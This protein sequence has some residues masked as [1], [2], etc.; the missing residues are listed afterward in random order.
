[1]IFRDIQKNH[2]VY[3]LDKSKVELSQ[4][5]V[6]E[7]APHISAPSVNT[8]ASGTQPMRDVTIEVGGK[9]TA[10]TIPEHLSVTYAG[11]LVLATERSGLIAEVEKMKNEAESVLESVERMKQVREKSDLLLASLNP[12]VREKQ[13]TERRFKSIEGDISGIKGMMQKLLDKLS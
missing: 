2:P 7:A 11:E 12:A 4:G 1:M 6:V 3:I 8:I 9:M 13:E 10:Y 5:K